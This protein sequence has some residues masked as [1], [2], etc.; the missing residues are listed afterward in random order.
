MSAGQDPGVSQ[1]LAVL[2]SQSEKPVWHAMYPH[3]PNAQTA[4]ACSTAQAA[5]HA[6][7]FEVSVLVLTSQPSL[8]RSWLQS[9]NPEAQ[10]PVHTPAAQAD[11]TT[12]LV[13]HFVPHP[14][15]FMASLVMLVAQPLVAG[16]QFTRPAAHPVATHEG[17][18]PGMQNWV[19]VQAALHAPQLLVVLSGVTQPPGSPPGKPEQSP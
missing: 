19:D 8:C 16:G 2:P 14:P 17:E 6:P 15:Q 4:A 18:G 13:E 11:P 5:L 9:A 12:W 7:Q 1:P 3:T 10:V